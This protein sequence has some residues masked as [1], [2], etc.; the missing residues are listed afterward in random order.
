MARVIADNGMLISSKV[1][2][3]NNFNISTSIDVFITA[4]SAID[5]LILY[6]SLKAETATDPFPALTTGTT[7]EPGVYYQAAAS[8]PTGIITLD[9]LNQTDPVFIIKTDGALTVSASVQFILINGA[10]ANNIFWVAD[11]AISLGANSECYGTFVGL[12]ANTVGAGC[13]LVGRAL[14]VGGEIANSGNV[15]V[16][17]TGSQRT[18]GYLENFSLF[19]S[20]GALSN[21]G[22]NTIIGDVGTNLGAITGFGDAIITGN[23][24][25]NT[26]EVTIVY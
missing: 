10:T 16:P 20:S 9:G 23:I 7:V 22:V 3:T 8:T 1:G 2:V 14:S 26:S 11:G 4:V 24:Y 13:D 15:S 12:A 6:L 18:L 19:T 5:L 21:T 17:A 25:D